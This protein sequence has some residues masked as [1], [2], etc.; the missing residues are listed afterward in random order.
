[1]LP[2][3]LA[4]LLSAS[5]TNLQWTIV[6]VGRQKSYSVA[7]D[8]GLLT[9]GGAA[10]VAP[11]GADLAMTVT[12]QPGSPVTRLKV[13]LAD[14]SGKDR[15][16]VVRL[17]IGLPGEGWRWWHDL[18]TVETLAD[19]P[20]SDTAG[21]RGLPG[22]PFFDDAE[23]PEFGRYSVYPLGVVDDGAGWLG[24]ARPMAP[25]AIVRFAGSGGAEPTLT[26]EVDLALAGATRPSREADFELWVLSGD[27]AAGPPMRQ[28]LADC[29][30]AD[31]DA[32]QQRTDVFG[33]WMPFADL[34]KIPNVDEFR[35]AFQEGAS[36]AGFDDRLG[37]RSFV[38]FHCAGEFAKV[39]GYQRGTEPQP[40]YETVIAAFDQVAEAH[41]GVPKVWELCGI[42]NAAGQVDYRPESTYGDFFCQGCVDPDLPYGA[43]MI[44]KLMQR[45]QAAKFPEGVDGVYYDGIAAGLDYDPRHLQAANHLLLWDA[46]LGRPLNY[47]LFSSAEW[48]AAIHD[49]L[50]GTGKLTMLND[51]S[52]SSFPFVGPSIDVLGGEISIHLPRTQRRIVRAL[53]GDKPFCSLVKA[54]YTKISQAAIETFMRRC[55]AYAMQPG[56]FD[57]TPSGAHPG[58]SYWVHPEWY[59]RDR[60]LFRRYLPLAGELARAHWQPVPETMVDGPAYIERFGGGPVSYLTVS[61]D[62]AEDL[63]EATPIT[64]Q[65]AFAK[66]GDAAVE[67]LTGRFVPD[68]RT[69]R[70]PMTPED[71]AVWAIGQPRALA[72]AALA[73]A[74]ELL[75][76]RARYLDAGRARDGGLTPWTPYGQGGARIAA[77]GVDGSSGLRIE[78]HEGQHYAGATQT[79]ALN[80]KEARPLRVTAQGRVETVTGAADREL[81]LYVDCYYTDGTALYGQTASLDPKVKGWQFLSVD[82]EP[83]KPVRNVNVYLLMRGNH[84]GVVQLDDAKAVETAMP[85]RNLLKRGDFEGDTVAPLLRTS[86]RAQAVNA[87]FAA[88]AQALATKPWDQA[89]CKRQLTVAEEQATL[90]DW[91]ADTARTLR[92]VAD[93]RWHLDAAA[94]CLAGSD[95]EPVRASRSTPNEALSDNSPRPQPTATLRYQAKGGAVPSGT[96]VEVDSNFSGYRPNVLTDGQVN[97]DKV[98]WTDVA[99]ASD[100]QPKEHWITLRFPKPTT[101]RQMTVWWAKDEGQLRASATLDL[102]VP[103]GDDWR[104]VAMGEPQGEQTILAAPGGP[105]TALRLRQPAGGGSRARP[106]LL[107]VSE[108]ATE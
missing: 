52:L 22:L 71:L 39:P 43:Q 83:A 42:R 12:A 88:V 15:G 37:A 3:L 106:N 68:A 11:A 61:T 48:A 45:V 108:I 60:E 86:E 58:S 17:T 85:D 2:T 31:P 75:D 5:P 97:P 1:M 32:W 82:I 56:F 27:N 24:L 33:Q 89:A 59:N 28:A 4:C 14:R 30:A 66:P 57:I 92:D 64:I 87:A 8:P 36:N 98:H 63:D 65:P 80:A 99:W 90:A 9:G 54:D 25:V 81:G 78:R 18:D 7:G 40:P 101:V 29:Y 74:E 21:L 41:S 103:D 77:D 47:N 67:L 72:D 38:Y 49:R 10:T 51:S 20:L 94:A 69:I 70:Q 46:K 73:R 55:V 100:D 102:Q 95:R 76:R 44:E 105:L 96:V 23:R 104:T 26:A 91:G 6:D 16:L 50:A 13:H 79:I 62:P 93:L 34:A 53:C 35:F 84:Y 107:W 19:Q